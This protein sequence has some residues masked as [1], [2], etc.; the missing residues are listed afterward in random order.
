MTHRASQ[1][2]FR[3]LI[4]LVFAMRHKSLGTIHGNRDGDWDSGWT[5]EELWLQSG[6]KVHTEFKSTRPG[7]QWAAGKSGHSRSSNA[8][9][10]V[11]TLGHLIPREKWPLSVI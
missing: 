10:K 9:G 11:A 3:C 6:Q 7:I 8:E 2:H 5:I 4:S 1:P